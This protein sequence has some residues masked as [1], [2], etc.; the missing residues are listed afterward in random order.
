MKL[1]ILDLDFETRSTIDLRKTGMYVYAEHPTT[2]VWVACWSLNG[3]AVQTWYPGQ[4]VPPLLAMHVRR[5]YPIYAHNAMFERV[6]WKHILT[7][8]Y[9]WPEPKLEQFY[10]TASMAAAMAL[11]RDLE[12]ACKAMGLGVEKDMAGHRLMLQMAKPRRL[13]NGVPTWWDVPEKVARLSAYCKRDVEAQVALRKRVRP[14]RA[15][16]RQLWLL[17]CLINER[18]VT[19]D[20]KAVAHASMVVKKT[21]ARLNDELAKLTGHEVTAATQRDNLVYWLNK[22]GVEC[23]SLAK[24]KLAELLQSDKLLPRER[25]VLEIRQAASKSSTAKLEA[26]A[27]RTC[28][29]GQLRENLMYHGASTGRWAG[30]GVQL[31]NL[32]RGVLDLTPEQVGEAIELMQYRDPDMLE[33]MYGPALT[34]VSDCLRGFIVSKP[35]YRLVSADFSNIEGRVLAWLAGAKRKL[36][37]FESFDAG[38][39]PDLYKVAA[40]GIYATAVDDIDKKKRQVGKTAELAC[41]YQGGVKA[42]HSMAT[43]YAVDMSEAYPG[44]WGQLGS[45]ERELLDDRYDKYRRGETKDFDDAMQIF[46]GADNTVEQVRALLKELDIEEP[47]FLSRE[48]WIASEV[49]KQLWRKDN[50]EIVQYWQDLEEAAL[51][52]V[53]ARGAVV[54]CGKVRFRVASNVLWCQLPSGR[55]LAYVDAKERVVKTP[56]GAE[57][58]TVTFMGVNSLTRQWQRQKSYGGLWA[59]NITQAVARDLLAEAMLRVE[60]NGYPVILSVHDELVSAIREGFGSLTEYE[61]LMTVL[62]PWA[63]GL[64]VKAEGWIANRY[65]K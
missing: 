14:L 7:P 60:E 49:T 22:Q 61:E 34:V 51:D 63:E 11:P 64:P 10:C 42:F 32:P 56:W 38:T 53:R 50:P 20:R 45:E 17:D 21:L 36:R 25:R 1:P 57:K 62:P 46:S 28:M 3:G 37:A 39:G 52:A 59:E 40:A 47:Q 16:E 44:L 48:T 33:L 54:E 31:Q 24:N 58:T 2:D 26:Y 5:G 9:G 15:Q 8:R 55:C 41:G 12:R 19:V 35:G 43:I 27:N 4:P 29:D 13:V 30:K 65:Q 18:G 6:I 23:T